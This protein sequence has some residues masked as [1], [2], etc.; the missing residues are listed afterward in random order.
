MMMDEYIIDPKWHC[1]I[2]RLA[3]IYKETFGY[4][5]YGHFVEVGAY[6]GVSWSD[7]RA[8]AL[9]G[10]NGLYVEP[11]P[12]HVERCREN[13][14]D[15]P[16]IQVVEAC[17]GSY[18]GTVT[19]YENGALTSTDPK[20]LALL[21][22]QDWARCSLER[23]FEARMYRLETLL[24][25]LGWPRRYDLLVID[26]EGTELD[27]MLGA[28]L[29]EWHPTLVIIETHNTRDDRLE[30]QAEEINDAMTGYGYKPIY[31]DR[32]NVIYR[33]GKP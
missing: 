4:R 10:W 3:S 32:L 20:F 11:V 2:P 17:C 31:D 26:T 1:Q 18:D 21:D 24:G 8:L 7:T 27:V 15:L 29:E 25:E 5:E 30:R 13:C 6:N 14:K 33:G 22:A 19:V 23:P 9:L 28:N 16:N 12:L